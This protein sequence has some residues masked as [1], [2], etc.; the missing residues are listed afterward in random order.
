MV[1]DQYL[2]FTL[3]IILKLGIKKKKEAKLLKLEQ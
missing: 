3:L 2:S 1:G